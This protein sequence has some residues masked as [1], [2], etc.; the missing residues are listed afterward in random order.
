[1]SHTEKY[2]A[3]TSYVKHNAASAPGIK[4]CAIDIG[5]SAVKCFTDNCRASFPSMAI[6]L[7]EIAF[8][9]EANQTDILY[10]D[11]KGTWAVGSIAVKGMSIRDTNES[12]KTLYSR[13]RYD[14]E[15]FK[16]IYRVGMGLCMMEEEG[17]AE[18]I[19]ACDHIPERVRML[20][21]IS[22]ETFD[23]GPFS[24]GDIAVFIDMAE[25]LLGAETGTMQFVRAL[26]R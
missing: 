5:Y 25:K 7:K 16:I 10:R 14:S 8:S 11:E 4:V 17:I 24:E 15:L 26:I 20:L 12:E 1:M 22:S 6:P 2:C 18:G 13:S 21:V 23:E 3:K 19:F 9:G